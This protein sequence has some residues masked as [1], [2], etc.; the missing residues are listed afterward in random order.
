[1]FF[2]HLLLCSAAAGLTSCAVG[3]KLSDIIAKDKAKTSDPSQVVTPHLVNS[4]YYKTQKPIE[5]SAP[6]N[7]TTNHSPLSSLP[8]APSLR[9]LRP[10][11][12][13][14]AASLD[15]PPGPF[16]VA[17]AEADEAK[18]PFAPLPEPASPFPYD[19]EY[20]FAPLTQDIDQPPAGDYPIA[21]ARAKPATPRYLPI[22]TVRSSPKLE[23]KSNL[24][25]A[26]RLAPVTILDAKG[27]DTA[28][29]RPNALSQIDP[30]LVEKGHFDRPLI[31]YQVLKDAVAEPIRAGTQTLRQA[32]AENYKTNPSLSAERTRLQE[33]DENYIQ[34]RAQGR[35]S[36]NASAELD[37][38]LRRVPSQSRFGPAGFTTESG[39]PREAS[40]QISQ[41]LYQGGRIKALKDQ[42]KSGILAARERLRDAEQSNALSAATVYTDL[43]RDRDIANIRRE[44]L[45]IVMRLEQA[46]K[47][48][49]ETGVG[50]RTD[51]FQAKTRVAN[52]EIALAESEAQLAITLANYDRIIGYPPL[53]IAPIPALNLPETLDEALKIAHNNNPRFRALVRDFNASFAAIK[54]AD[55]LGSPTVALTGTAEAERGQLTGLDRRDAVALALQINVPFYSGGANKSRKREAVAVKDRIYYEVLETERA[56]EQIMAELWAANI[57]AQQSYAQSQAQTRFAQT[58]YEGVKD[59]QLFGQRD[60]L[61]V[62]NAQAELQNAKAQEAV[63]ARN[64]HI[65]AFRLLNTMGVFDAY[66]LGLPVAIYDYADYLDDIAKLK[67]TK[68]DAKTVIEDW[69][70]PVLDSEYPTAPPF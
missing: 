8:P 48:R 2:K 69:V 3:S 1:M 68:R 26:L 61:D 37:Y 11:P 54:V 44:D 63:A 21:L 31:G 7:S 32:I 16:P 52:S 4:G 39:H 35:P 18:P 51:I 53:N 64:I 9:Q 17:M 6:D 38:T 46:A 15:L 27:P 24:P 33:T 43:L 60:I 28:P 34:A 13:V 55:A 50:T 25:T 42:A 66:H 19:S 45:R 62:L 12:D 30:G 67:Y 65:T 5:S 40:V 57:A 70:E 56:V 10:N 14:P 59:E 29:E 22:K 23:F 20:E 47:D 49:F 36:A 58:A 41:P